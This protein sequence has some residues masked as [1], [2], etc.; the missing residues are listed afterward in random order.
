M[1]VDINDAGTRFTLLEAEFYPYACF[2]M[3]PAGYTTDFESTPPWIRSFFPH[4]SRS[5]HAAVLHDWIYDQHHRGKDLC[6]RKTA[7]RF[8]REQMQRDGVGFRTRWTFWFFVRLFGWI[9]W[10][11]REN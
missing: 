2:I 5:S 9:Y 3:V 4:P 1:K 6:D 11:K 7:D 8:L 10:N